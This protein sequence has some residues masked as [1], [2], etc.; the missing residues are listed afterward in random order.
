MAGGVST[1]RLAAAVTDAG[2]LGFLAAGY[3]APSQTEEEIAAVRTLTGGPFGV[4]IFVPQRQA[5]DT[6]AVAAYRDALGPEAERYQVELATA[7][8]GPDDD[9]WAEKLTLVASARV[10]VVS[11]TF[12]CPSHDEIER[13]RAAGCEIVVTVTGAEEAVAAVAA[14]A[15]ALVVQSAE[16]GG[17]RGS[18]DPLPLTA[19]CVDVVT[20]LGQ[21]RPSV[22]V[23]LVAAGGIMD[24]SGLNAVLMAGAVAGQLGTAFL[25]AIEAGTAPAYRAAL[26]AH[27]RETVVTTAFTG[28]AARALANRF[29]AEYAATA[30]TPYPQVHH[31]TRPIRA[32]AAARGDAEAMALWAGTGYRSGREGSAAGIVAAIADEMAT[33][34]DAR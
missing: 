2:G 15:D 26:A 20:L 1:P 11:F 30:P 4:N 3:Q 28:R 21:V 6:A 14:G 32:A 31:L 29:T 5:V 25:R 17:H 10:P 24:G 22:A 18:F 13:L 23:P 19:P 8:T 12:G 34:R 16:A 27:H 7:P 33:A 9:G